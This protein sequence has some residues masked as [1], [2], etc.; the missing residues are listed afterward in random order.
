MINRRLMPSGSIK[1]EPRV[2]RLSK[3]NREASDREARS[4]P[5]GIQRNWTDPFILRKG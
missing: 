4:S 3:L 5:V 2:T 1:K